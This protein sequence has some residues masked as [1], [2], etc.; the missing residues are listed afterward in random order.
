VRSVAIPSLNSAMSH[1]PLYPF[2]EEAVSLERH[3]KLPLHI[4]TARLGNQADI[5]HRLQ[6]MFQHWQQISGQRSPGPSEVEFTGA[7]LVP[8]SGNCLFFL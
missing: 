8:A 1:S 6:R 4:R 5:N 2:E 3:C 7:C